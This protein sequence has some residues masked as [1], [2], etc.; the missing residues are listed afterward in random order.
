MSSAIILSAAA[1]SLLLKVEAG[2]GRALTLPR[3]SGFG[4]F[5]DSKVCR[6]WT[7]VVPV[8][9]GGFFALSFS[10]WTCKSAG[11]TGGGYVERWG[12]LENKKLGGTKQ[13]NCDSVI[14]KMSVSHSC[15]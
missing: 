3:G 8:G 10:G 1:T 7:T 12:G 14:Q 11:G 6:G 9:L 13:L 5:L 15:E 2:P 4:D